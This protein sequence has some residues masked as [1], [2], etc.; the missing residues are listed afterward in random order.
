M[1]IS[2]NLTSFFIYNG[3]SAELSILEVGHERCNAAKKAISLIR[4]HYYLHYVTRG[5][6]YFKI[7]DKT[8]FIKAGMFFL[9]IPGVT[10]E[11]RPNKDDPWEYYWIG[12]GGALSHDYMH[13]LNID[14]TSPVFETAKDREII[15][16]FERLLNGY[17]I[18]G[19]LD[20]LGLSVLTELFYIIAEEQSINN[21]NYVKGS[22]EHVKKA[23]DYIHSQYNRPIS[24]A[25]IAEYLNLNVNY[26][27]S[28]FKHSLGCQPSKYIINYK[29]NK[30]C[31]ILRTVKPPINQVANMVG[32]SDPLYF[33]RVFTKI[34]GIPPSRFID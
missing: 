22:Q 2:K 34:K 33:S 4:T 32:F 13:R 12:F 20:L 3:N 15:Q 23:I 5:S 8:Y 16:A 1:H 11:Y 7:Y 24:V 14:E 18:H 21:T 10:T 28:L 19:N 30:A 29:I 31:E 17:N 9:L 25:E 27:C 6:G 26:F